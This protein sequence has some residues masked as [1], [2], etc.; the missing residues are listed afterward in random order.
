MGNVTTPQHDY[1]EGRCRNCGDSEV[2][3]IGRDRL[4]KRP[5]EGPRPIPTSIF[6]GVDGFNF[7]HDRMQEL[8]RARDA[9]L[10]QTTTIEDAC[11]I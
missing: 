6:S 8:Q 2:L 10:A 9:I 5:P 1:V 3:N 11:V 4:C 7:I